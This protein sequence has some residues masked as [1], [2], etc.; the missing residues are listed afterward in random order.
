MTHSPTS[1][2]SSSHQNLNINQFTNTVTD[3]TFTSASSH[4]ST[5]GLGCLNRGVDEPD[6]SLHPTYALLGTAVT[7]NPQ[8]FHKSSSQMAVGSNSNI[9]ETNGENGYFPVDT[10]SGY[11]SP[12]PASFNSLLP[13]T[14]TPHTPQSAMPES[15]KA[16][17]A[18]G[19]VSLPG[20]TSPE[21]AFY[22][23]QNRME[24][25]LCQICG[26]L[27]AGFH[28][29]AYVCEA[30]KKFF[31]RHSLANGRATTTCPSGGKC[32]IAKTSRGRCQ[33][34]RYKKCL[35]V[36]MSL[37]DMDGQGE[38]D[39]SNIPCRVCGGRSSGFHFGAL[40]C[41]GCKGFFRRTEEAAGRLVCVGGKDNCTITPRSRNVCKACR[42]RRCLRAGM[43]KRGSRIGRQPNAVKFHCAIEIRQLQDSGQ[44]LAS[45]F[46]AE[47]RKHCSLPTLLSS[48]SNGP[49]SISPSSVVSPAGIGPVASQRRA[50]AGA[51]DLAGYAAS[52][53]VASTATLPKRK[54][55]APVK[56]EGLIGSCQDS[57]AAPASLIRTQIPG[58]DGSPGSSSEATVLRTVGP[59]EEVMLDGIAWFNYG[60]RTATEFLRLPNAYF[61]SRF[62][63]SSID[64]AHVDDAHRVWGHVMN[65]FHLH[66]QQIVQ[67][68]KLI[69]G[70][71]QLSLA[72]RGNLV[73]EG[74]YPVMLLLMA[75]DFEPAEGKYN[76]FDF[77]PSE[78]DVILRHFPSYNRVV[79]HLSISGRFFQQLNLSLSEFSF[80]CAIEILRNFQILTGQS[81][82][83]AR[84]LLILAKHSLLAG[85]RSQN[86]PQE[87]VDHKWTRLESLSEMLT[88]MSKEHQDIAIQMKRTRP[89]LGYPDLYV[90]MYQL[91]DP[92]FSA[93][94]LMN[95]SVLG[96]G[97]TTD[98]SDLASETHFPSTSVLI[99]QPVATP[100]TTIGHW[101]LQSHAIK[102]ED[103]NWSVHDHWN[104]PGVPSANP[105]Q[106]SNFLESSRPGQ[107]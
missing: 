3:D 16:D 46:A 92:P 6:S 65:H 31:M 99:Q 30:C 97:T 9:T 100:S 84:K 76:Y 22:Q 89:D 93:R 19:G 29:G 57:V 68:A 25:Q 23:Y 52:T 66:S 44:L 104:A 63:I 101:Q 26:E 41:E 103:S 59:N 11:Y 75:R 35:E 8:F 64:P 18:T 105:Y 38:L 71:N 28:H 21:S 4:W 88:S 37:K 7:E 15:P 39:I 49:P 78:R 53:L 2:S 70:F 60:M 47:S 13:R 14:Q 102:M 77:T 5:P 74:M 56:L 73:R 50:S 40:T 51:C 95:V 48:P 80:V 81:Y 94:A 17:K 69:P 20:F 43:S 86:Q 61:K 36:G 96:T 55:S 24:G 82:T 83:D 34:C 58:C 106:I 67:F 32:V 79:E 10:G 98:N 1:T 42:F 91:T 33:Q 72:G 54:A 85:M 90:E 45:E 12:Q 27:A 62:D 107:P 87:V